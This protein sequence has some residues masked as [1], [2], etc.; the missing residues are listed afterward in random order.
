MGLK[1][2]G[3]GRSNKFQLIIMTKRHDIS[4]KVYTFV[5]I[6]TLITYDGTN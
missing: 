1:T 3:I 4:C 2:K 6:R 5:R